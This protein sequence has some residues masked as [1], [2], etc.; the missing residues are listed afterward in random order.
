MAK[1]APVNVWSFLTQDRESNI[2]KRTKAI[3]GAAVSSPPHLFASGGVVRLLKI[4][5][6]AQKGRKIF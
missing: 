4:W 3:Q 2:L 6:P 5:R 1:S